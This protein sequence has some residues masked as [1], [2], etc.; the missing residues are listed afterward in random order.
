MTESFTVNYNNIMTNGNS[1]IEHLDCGCN[2]SK[3]KSKY[4]HK[5]NKQYCKMISKPCKHIIAVKHYINSGQRVSDDLLAALAEKVDH[6]HICKP[7]KRNAIEMIGQD[8]YNKLQH[9][10]NEFHNNAIVSKLWITVNDK[11]SNKDDDYFI[12]QEWIWSIIRYKNKYFLYKIIKGKTYD[13][14]W[15]K[16]KKKNAFICRQ[17]TL[18]LNEIR[19]NQSS[20]QCKHIEYVKRYLQS[21]FRGMNTKLFKIMMNNSQYSEKHSTDIVRCVD[22]WEWMWMRFAE[23]RNSWICSDNEFK[24]YQIHP[25]RS[26]SI[27]RGIMIIEK[28]RHKY[29]ICRDRIRKQIAIT[30]TKTLM[31][32]QQFIRCVQQG[33]NSKILIKQLLESMLVYFQANNKM[34]AISFILEYNTACIEMI[35]KMIKSTNVKRCA[36]CNIQH[37]KHKMFRCKQCGEFYCCR[38]HQKMHWNQLQNSHKLYCIQACVWLERWIQFT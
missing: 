37:V 20:T 22:N 2:K 5:N 25:Y 18:D 35:D 21:G 30:H 7:L 23:N 33:Y 1:I 14:C 9:K 6:P 15:R 19:C 29:F 34:Q 24:R 4:N 28:N 31:Q 38:L 26:D 3:S 10:F 8:F 12:V 36:Y 11:K 17:M 32:Y 16:D 13:I 27:R